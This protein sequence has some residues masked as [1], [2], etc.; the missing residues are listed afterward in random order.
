M[1]RAL[2]NRVLLGDENAIADFGESEHCAVIDWRDGLAEIVA[3][4]AP[5]LPA[6]HMA[7]GR[8]AA[9]EAEIVVAGRAPIPIA[10]SPRPAQESLLLSVNKALQPDFELRQFRPVDGDGYALFVAPRSLWSEAERSHP[11]AIE[12]LFLSVER[13]SAYWSKSYLARLFTNP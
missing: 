6:G 12:K 11:Q 13:L 10:L 1:D 7:L 5:F 3:A 2:L 9:S 8:L 4:V